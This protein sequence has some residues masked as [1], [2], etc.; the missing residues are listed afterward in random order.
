MSALISAAPVGFWSRP[1]GDEVLE[2][3]TPL[4]KFLLPNVCRGGHRLA[5]PAHVH[6]HVGGVHWHLTS[7]RMA[8]LGSGAPSTSPPPAAKRQ[9]PTCVASMRVCCSS[10]SLHRLRPCMHALLA[11]HGRALAA[12][13]EPSRP[14]HPPS[15]ALPP[16]CRDARAEQRADKPHPDSRVPCRVCM[17]TCA[18]VIHHCARRHMLLPPRHMSFT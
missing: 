11:L 18:S 9:R 13:A 4:D 14:S 1:L 8:H 5:L 16:L 15:A 10:C 3:A 7:C 12:K 2:P 6:S 17:C